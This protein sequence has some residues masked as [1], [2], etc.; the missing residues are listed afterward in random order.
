MMK[1]RFWKKVL[2]ALR[3][4]NGQRAITTIL[5]GYP[6]SLAACGKLLMPGQMLDWLKNLPDMISDRKIQARIK[7]IIFCETLFMAKYPPPQ[8]VTLPVRPMT[9][10][11]RGKSPVITV[12]GMKQM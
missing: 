3:E 6:R 8:I 4:N 10:A 7:L 1:V 9:E 5:K 2:R 11:T 12:K